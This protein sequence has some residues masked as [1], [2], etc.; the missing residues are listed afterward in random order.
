MIPVG[1]GKNEFTAARFFKTLGGGAIGFYF[2][3]LSTP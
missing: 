2:R 3:H 1:L